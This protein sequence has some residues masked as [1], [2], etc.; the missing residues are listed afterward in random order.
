MGPGQVVHPWMYPLQSEQV[1]D[2]LPVAQGGAVSQMQQLLEFLDIQ[3]AWH[4]VILHRQRGRQTAI[5]GERISR[6]M[7]LGLVS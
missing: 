6:L 7:G 5:L 2:S 1:F 4:N 3:L